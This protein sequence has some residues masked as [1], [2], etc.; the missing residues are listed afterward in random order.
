MERLGRLAD[1][2][3]DTVAEAIEDVLSAQVWGTKVHSALEKIIEAWG[4]EELAAFLGDGYKIV[5]VVD[6]KTG[7]SGISR[8]R[9]SRIQKIF[10]ISGEDLGDV[11]RTLR[12]S[13]E[14]PTS[15]YDEVVVKLN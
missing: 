3:H 14:R 15:V 7:R 8:S 10:G 4:D 12:P 9:A 13:K 11:L 1:Q 2:A 5:R 6:L